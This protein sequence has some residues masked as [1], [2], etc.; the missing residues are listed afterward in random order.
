[1]R[2]IILDTETTGI[3]PQEGHRIVEIGCVEVINNVPT[4][5]TYHQYINPERDMPAEAERIHGLSETFLADKPTFSE[6]AG[7]FMDFIGQDQMVIHNAAFDMKHINAELDRLGIGAIP[8]ARATDSLAIARKRFPGAQ[9]SLDALCR[10]FGVDNSNRQLHGA[11]LDAQLL[12]EVYLE[13]RGGRE[14]GLGLAGQTAGGGLEQTT[15]Q[16]SDKPVR[17]ARKH[18]IPETEQA[19]HRKAVSGLKDSLWAKMQPAEFAGAEQPEA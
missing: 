3:D 5:R 1:M 7:A 14:P 17:P 13:L 16:A 11:L 18:T 6:V 15:L 4:G 9:S 8:M 12:A 19:A 10:R 2:E